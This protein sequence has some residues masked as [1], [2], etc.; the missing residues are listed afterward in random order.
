MGVPG[1]DE[2][3]C[4][5]GPML[6]AGVLEDGEFKA[7]RDVIRN[8]KLQP[9]FTKVMMRPVDADANTV[10]LKCTIKKNGANTQG[11][12]TLIAFDKFGKEVRRY[13][14]V[15]EMPRD[16]VVTKDYIIHCGSRGMF[17]ILNRTN[18]QVVGETRFNMRPFALCAMGDNKVLV[19]DDRS[20]KLYR[21]D[22]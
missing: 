17:R 2:F 4:M 14:G 9:E 3:Y 6:R 8:Y 18:G 16:W 11:V 21:I 12:P 20:E 10:Y 13:E 1:K 5:R 7:T 22:F 15:S 19:Y